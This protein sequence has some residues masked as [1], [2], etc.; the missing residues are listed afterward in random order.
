[1][2]K[3]ILF[4]VDGV[5]LN[6]ESFAHSMEKDH[7]ISY[8]M[9]QPFFRGSFPATISG[10]AD[11]KEIIS[12]YLKVWGWK[13]SVEDFLDY[14]F[15]AEHKIDQPL[16]EHIQDL[17]ARG[18]KCFLAT[19]Q[20][21]YRAAYILEKIGFR[22]AFDG[23][24]ISSELGVKKPDLKF[25]EQVHEKLLPI[26]KESILFWD[27]LEENVLAARGYG[28]VAEIYTSFEDYIQKMKKYV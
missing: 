1:M 26:E 7:G 25:F 16:V 11:L 10:D 13:G 12:P 23:T 24:F 8:D 18:V 17:R 20:E 15:K 21:R 2:K 22:D 5:L 27:D 4:D 3:V 6:G 28:F 14:W 9:V 19:N